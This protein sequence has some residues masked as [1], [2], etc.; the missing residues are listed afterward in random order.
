LSFSNAA[1][2]GKS[3]CRVNSGITDRRYLASNEGLARKDEDGR[4][5][6]AFFD[7]G[8]NGDVQGS[9]GGNLEAR[10]LV[11]ILGG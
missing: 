10:G 5:D 6:T 7:G 3:Q 9:P 2:P 11:S 1:S 8:G 4:H